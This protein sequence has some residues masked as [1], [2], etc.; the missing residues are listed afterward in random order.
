MDIIDA[1]L[2]REVSCKDCV[3][4]DEYYAD[5][6]G[7]LMNECLKTNNMA[8]MVDRTAKSCVHYNPDMT[9]DVQ[10]LLERNNKSY[11]KIF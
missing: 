1:M 11:D 6:Y 5:M 8:F 2:S 9:I 4:Y 10:T 7:G 3:Y